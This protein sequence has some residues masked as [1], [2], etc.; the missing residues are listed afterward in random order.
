MSLGAGPCV[1]LAGSRF[2]DAYAQSTSLWRTQPG[3]A[4]AAPR[5]PLVLDVHGR[6]NRQAARQ[7]V[8]VFLRDVQLGPPPHPDSTRLGE[9]ASRGAQL[10]E[11]ARWLN[12]ADL[13]RL[14]GSALDR[15]AYLAEAIPRG[16]G[17]L[18]EATLRMHGHH[19]IAVLDEQHRFRGAV[20][21]RTR[22]LEA[23]AKEFAEGRAG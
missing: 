6:L 16:D 5:E 12:G 19:V 20:V 1:S 7:L 10:V 17:E 11:H 3:G 14:L 22:A 4:G 8:Q 21:H 9:R 23:L 18:A 13:D 15:F 2:A